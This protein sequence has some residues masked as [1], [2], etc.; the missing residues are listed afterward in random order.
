MR[1]QS[2]A[3][4]ALLMGAL[5]SFQARAWQRAELSGPALQADA[6]HAGPVMSRAA[7]RGCVARRDALNDMLERLR[8]EDAAK[9]VQ[10]LEIKQLKA[11]IALREPVVDQHSRESVEGYNAMIDRAVALQADYN[12]GMKK[13][14]GQYYE[15]KRARARF[16]EECH[17]AYYVRDLP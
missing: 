2:C 9:N 11:E 3:A 6:K 5:C 7:L 14:G 12:A 15:H 10:A 4:L 8:A 1:I 17:G 16:A 13:L